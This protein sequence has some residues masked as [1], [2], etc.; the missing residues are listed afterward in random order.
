MPTSTAAATLALAFTDALV[1]FGTFLLAFRIGVLFYRRLVLR[2]NVPPLATIQ[3]LFSATFAVSLS[4]VCIILYDAVGLMHSAT[5]RLNWL[6]NVYMLLLLLVLVLPTAQVYHVLVDLRVPASRSAK[7]A[8][9]VE[10]IFLYVF[11]RIGEPPSKALHSEF[12]SLWIN[13]QFLF[14]TLSGRNAA[15]VAFR[16]AEAA[17]ARIL[18]V[19]TT[20]LAVLAGLTAVNLPYAYLGW[21]FHRVSEKDVAAL[22]NRLNIAVEN[23]ASEKRHIL[24]AQSSENMNNSRETRIIRH[25]PETV[26][27]AERRLNQLFEQYNYA[28]TA[29]GEVRFARTIVGRLFTF[30]GTIMLLLCGVRIFL[31]VYNISLRMR[32]ARLGRNGSS[33]LF[34]YLHLALKS[35]GVQ[36]SGEAVYQYATLLFTSVLL[37]T[38]LRAALRRMSLVFT[39]ISGHESLSSSAPVFI[40]HLLGIYVISSTILVRPFLPPGTRVLISDVTGNM[41][42]QRFLQIFDVLFISSAFVAAVSVL[43]AR[44]RTSPRIALGKRR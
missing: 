41:N 42:L 16:F 25:M 35:F 21:F 28:V 9:V 10:L 26:L 22:E 13:Q 37:A 40:A 6:F 1:S 14:S 33:K 31:A 19:G 36:V 30:L 8:I 5:R 23:I 7:A 18:V 44:Q 11:W 2:E 39:L 4:F 32:G 24:N 15:T 34:D 43:L 3:F 27:V 20:L 12:S 17:M 38:N 29:L